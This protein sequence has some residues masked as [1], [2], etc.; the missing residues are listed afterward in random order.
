MN[1]VEKFADKLGAKVSLHSKKTGAGKLVIEYDNL[2]HLDDIMS[3][4]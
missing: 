4:F 3:K 2:E 1:L